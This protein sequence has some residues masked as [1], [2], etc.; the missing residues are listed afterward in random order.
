MPAHWGREV[1]GR[2]Q[3]GG[4]GQNRQGGVKWGEGRTAKAVSGSGLGRGGIGASDIL[5]D[6]LDPIL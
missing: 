4:A 3:R 5:S 2:D 1:R 6:F